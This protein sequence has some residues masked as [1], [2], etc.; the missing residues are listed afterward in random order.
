[1]CC[2]KLQVACNWA[3]LCC[4]W[5]VN[6]QHAKLSAKVVE[7]QL[8]L[9][10]LWESAALPLGLFCCLCFVYLFSFFFFFLQLI[11]I[12]FVVNTLSLWG[13]E[14]LASCCRTWQCNLATW[15]KFNLELGYFLLKLIYPLLGSNKLAST[16]KTIKNNCIFILNNCS[17]IFYEL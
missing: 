1:M 15:Y 14:L 7:I 3:L 12:N 9:Q 11:W 8:T 5:W 2:C 16:P 17:W 4:S 10:S 6:L 13:C